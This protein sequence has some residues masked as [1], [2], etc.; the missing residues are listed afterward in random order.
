MAMH[1]SNNYRLLVLASLL[2]LLGGCKKAVEPDP[3]VS[4]II[5]SQAYATDAS[6]IGVLASIYSYMSQEKNFAQGTISVGALTGLAGDELQPYPDIPYT[7]FYTNT[8]SAAQFI[9]QYFWYD[10]YTNIYTCNAALEG[11]PSATGMSVSVKKQLIAEA[12]FLRA[13][14]YFY[15]VNLFGDVPLTTTTDYGINNRLGRTPTLQV[16]ELILQDLKQALPDLSPDFVD[17]YLQKVSDRIRPTKWAAA[18]LLSRVYLYLEQWS[19]AEAQATEV[20]NHSE[21]VLEPDLNRVF[22]FNSKE[23]IFQLQTLPGGFNTLE[24]DMYILDAFGLDKYYR[25]F[26]LRKPFVSLFEPGDRRLIKWIGRAVT[27]FGTPDTLYF[28]FKYKL[29]YNPPSS[30]EYLMVLRLAE[31]YLIRAEA[32]AEQGNLVGAKADLNIIRSRA[33]LAQTTAS[34]KT[35][36]LIAIAHE[37]QVELFTEWGHRWMDLRRTGA[38]DSVMT[39]VAVEKGTTWHPHNRLFPI[40][41]Y[42]INQNPNLVQNPGY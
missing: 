31:Q 17:G 29:R 41:Q 26:S 40:P 6:A 12:K 21:F 27:A 3:P 18:A 42:D 37:R 24:G 30:T 16:Y 22:L 5:G 32:R 36:T 7:L 4:L 15:L 34:T 2:L 13:F 28:P 33:G 38:L 19:N 11:M 39:K 25:P 23:A 14:F 8:L 35:E 20:I 1:L 10:A 9:P